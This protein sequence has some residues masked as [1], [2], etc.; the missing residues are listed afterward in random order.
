MNLKRVVA[1]HTSNTNPYLVRSH[2]A[3]DSISA[4]SSG[5]GHHSGYGD[6]SGYGHHSGYGSHSGHGYDCCPLVIDPL[7]FLALVGFIGAGTY[8]L[9]LAIDRSAIPVGGRKRSL[10]EIFIAGKKKLGRHFCD[11]FWTLKQ[12]LSIKNCKVEYETIISTP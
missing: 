12:Q 4:F 2:P 9:Q 8:L 10:E 1:S 5:Y 3:F 7:L 6:R 11:I